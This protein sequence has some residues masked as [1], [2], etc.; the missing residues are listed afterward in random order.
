[1]LKGFK[2][3]DK[4]LK[5]QGV[6]YKIGETAT[7]KGETSLCSSGLH[8]VENPLD[9]LAYYPPGTSR[10]AEVHA[11]GVAQETGDDS[12]RVCRSLK[13][14]SELSLSVL[15][16]FGVRFILDKVDWRSAKSNTGYGS[17]AT[18]T[19]YGSA[20]TNTGYRSAATSDGKSSAAVVTGLNSKARAGE[21]GCIALAWWNPKARR[22]EMR[23]AR[24]G[25]GPGRGLLK[26][27][28][29]YTLDAKGRFVESK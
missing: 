13:V 8:F 27:D 25:T 6:Q 20:A 2:G 19:G 17:A 23:C 5:C 4:D 12:K 29:W 16:G 15:V 9:V 22:N 11:D 24:T 21:Y 18:N 7:H 3:F 28:T 14:V 1:M 10:Y 26:P